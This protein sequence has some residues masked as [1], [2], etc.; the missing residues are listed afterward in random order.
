[1]NTSVIAWLAYIVFAEEMRAA[2]YSL[3]TTVTLLVL[4]EAILRVI[5]TLDVRGRRADL[6]LLTDDTSLLACQKP[7]IRV[8]FPIHTLASSRSAVRSASRD[9]SFR[10]VATGGN[11][12][13]NQS[14][15][16]TVASL[17]PVDVGI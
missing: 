17:V 14:W 9:G 10:A 2:L 6:R 3:A 11:I 12:S 8:V 1:M 15:S 4:Y 13:H 7:G 16:S 5:G